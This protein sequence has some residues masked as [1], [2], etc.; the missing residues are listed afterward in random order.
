[1]IS[2]KGQIGLKGLILIALFLLFGFTFLGYLLFNYPSEAVKDNFT[3]FNDEKINSEN[4][5]VSSP[6]T[7][8]K[9]IVRSTIGGVFIVNNLPIFEKD[10]TLE[11]IEFDGEFINLDLS[12]Q[13]GCESHSFVLYVLSQQND[14]QFNENTIVLY[15]DSAGDSCESLVEDS[16]SFDFNTA[17]KL[18][19][20]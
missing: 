18:N 9:E 10:Y 5:I 4:S 20:F 8:S 14:L 2:K 11:N 12:Y 1:M 16:L 6:E 3:N 17:I 7:F 15:H 19:N 13:G